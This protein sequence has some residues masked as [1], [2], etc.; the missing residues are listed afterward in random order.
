MR[1]LLLGSGGREHA[2]A[3]KLSESPL[4][5]KIFSAPG[6][7]GTEMCSE[8]IALDL[9]DFVSISDFLT[10]EEIDMLVVGPEQPLVGGLVDFIREDEA[11]KDLMIIGPY[12]D[13]AMLEGSKSY[14]K[15]FMQRHKIPTAAYLDVKQ[16]NVEEGEAFIDN[17][18]TP[19]VLKADGLAGGKGVLIIDSKEEAKSALKEM[20]DGQFGEASANVVIEEF[21]EGIEFS[22]FILTDGLGYKILPV[23]KDYKRIGENDTGLN[24][25]GMGAVSPP[26]F[27]TE[28]IMSQVEKDIIAP[29]LEGLRRDMIHYTGFIY[30]G[31][32]LTSEGSKVVEYNVRLGD[33]ETQAVLP[34]LE[35]D[36]LKLFQAAAQ[37][38]LSDETISISDDPVCTIILA[39]EGYPTSYEKGKTISGINEIEESY[40]YH[41]GTKNTDGTLSTNGGRVLAVSSRG[42]T[43]RKAIQTS[44]RSSEKINFEGKYF[45]KD[46]GQDLL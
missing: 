35:S 18:H 8:N 4:C 41:A 6:N 26:L 34:R 33:P 13:G 46:I 38:K 1:I 10:V 44:L 32:M 42:T 19:V 37:R 31:L 12:Q 25:G 43:L 40:I 20:L 9:G 21:M 17:G 22:V 27:V 11:L 39:S 16:D 30:I 2:M 5:S 29:T 24:T 14:A 28:E 45:R 23:A 15:S 3:L 36:L 7:P